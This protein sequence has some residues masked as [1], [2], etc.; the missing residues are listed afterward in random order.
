MQKHL[1]QKTSLNLSEVVDYIDNNKAEKYLKKMAKKANKARE[2][3][4]KNK[5]RA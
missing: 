3:K 4:Y 2:T 5:L 1:E